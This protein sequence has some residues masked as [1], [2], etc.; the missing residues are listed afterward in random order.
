MKKRC[1]CLVSI[2][3]V[4]CILFTNAAFAKDGYQLLWTGG[5]GQYSHTENIT[6]TH[7]FITKRAI[8]ILRND[9]KI[10]FY[11]DYIDILLKYAD[12]P[13]KD[14]I[15]YG[16]FAGHFYDPD[17]GKNY[18]GST[19]PTAQTK[20][21]E[22]IKLAK[23]YYEDGRIEKSMEE[24][25]RA[26]HFISDANVPHHAANKIAVLTNHSEFEKWVDENKDSYK[27][28]S[29][30]LYSKYEDRLDFMLESYIWNMVKDSAVNAKQYIDLALTNNE[31]N[32]DKVTEKTLTYSQEVVAAVLYNFLKKVDSSQIK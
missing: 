32:W 1:T 28:N 13:D 10:S 2:I 5:E 15:S 25:G 12:M 30:R 16:T 23:D 8:S 19:N 17:S 3:L 18:M 22:H 27:V 31:R 6:G 29:S 26:I 9:K 21:I 11:D 4:M 14:E 7:Q 20:A 24:L